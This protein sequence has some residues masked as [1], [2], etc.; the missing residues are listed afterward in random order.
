MIDTPFHFCRRQPGFAARASLRKVKIAVKIRESRD[1]ASTSLLFPARASLT[2]Y[3]GGLIRS[4]QDGEL[5]NKMA[6]E[7]GEFNPCFFRDLQP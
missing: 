6:V 2:P 4:D 7:R 5:N 3:Q 1:R